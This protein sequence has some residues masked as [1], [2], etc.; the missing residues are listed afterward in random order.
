MS[1]TETTVAR[2]GIPQGS[3]RVQVRKV[4]SDGWTAAKRG[5]PQVFV[6]ALPQV[7]RDGFVHFE[8]GE[9]ME[10]FHD[11]LFPLD[12][13][14]AAS[15]GPRFSTEVVTT[16][17]GHEHR[18]SQWSDAR[19]EYDAG[20]GVRSEA[21]LLTLAAFFRARRGRAAGFRF[22]DPID[23]DSSATGGAITPFD[24][25]LGSGD[26]VAT[27]F[28][29]VKRYGGDVVW[30]ERRITR[31]DPDSL[32]VAVLVSSGRKAGYWRRAAIW[33]SRRHPQTARRSRPVSGSM[34][35]CASPTI[36][37]IS[38]LP[39]SGPATCR[40]SRWSKSGK[41]HDRASRRAGGAHG[42]QGDE[43]CPLL[44]RGAD[45]WRGAGLHRA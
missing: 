34:C 10:A 28:A 20:L 11:V 24:Q 36:G 19:M 45:R 21:D 2:G 5:V 40:A 23:H 17:S 43:P 14:F 32:R 16:A 42:G 33:I 9:A 4:R 44:A 3:S 27:R 15:G 1:K 22:R 35:R 29:L 12:L 37:S 31:P 30:Q 38:G 6:W 18:N 8:E 26:G 13:G 25:P 41:R 7:I 39:I